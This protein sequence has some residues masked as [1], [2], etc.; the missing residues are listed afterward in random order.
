MGKAGRPAGG[1]A[2]EVARVSGWKGAGYQGGRGSR[3][4]HAENL[5]KGRNIVLRARS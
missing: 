2:G 1:V 4:Y 3:N 5:E